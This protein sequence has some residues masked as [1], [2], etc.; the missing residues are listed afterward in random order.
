MH[1]PLVLSGHVHQYR[2]LDQG[3]R[4]HLWAPTM[5]AVLPDEIQ[6]TVGLKRSGV[7]SLEFGPDATFTV[8]FVEPPGLKQFTLGRDIQNSYA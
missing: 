2:T 3:G 6:K 5:W 1:C 7:L 4:R 8:Q